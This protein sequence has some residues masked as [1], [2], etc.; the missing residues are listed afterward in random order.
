M[1][2][3]TELMYSSQSKWEGNMDTRDVRAEADRPTE[4]SIAIYFGIWVE[5]VIQM[6][7]Y[8]VIQF[9]NRKFIVCTS[10]LQHSLSVRCAA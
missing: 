9:R 4:K 7:Y 2:I 1:P 6:E 5:V 10:D 3:G 8:S